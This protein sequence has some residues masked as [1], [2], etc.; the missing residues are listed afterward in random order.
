M[1]SRR[2]LADSVNALLEEYGREPLAETIIGTMVGDGAAPLVERACAA[3]GVA[4]QPP[5]ALA[6]F[7]EHYDRRLT[8]HTKPYDGVVDMLA[9]LRARRVTLGVLTNKPQGAAERV[10]RGLTL[11]PWFDA[12]V[13]G[14][15]GAHPRKPDPA[16][17]LALAA[18]AGVPIE[19]TVLVGD[20]S[21]DVETARRAGARVCA[22]RYGYGFPT[23]EPL[24]TESDWVIDAPSELPAL[25][26]V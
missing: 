23:A 8:V 14:A 19:R 11:M 17:L 10:L 25:V 9:S 20:G 13:I 26:R 12:G 18:A 6:R 16:G 3:A 2:D 4:P 5:E 24:L 7:L 15:E 21:Q 1:D 22:A